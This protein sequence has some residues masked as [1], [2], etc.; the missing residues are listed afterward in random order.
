MFVEATYYLFNVPGQ[1]E[2][3]KITFYKV[4]PAMNGLVGYAWIELSAEMKKALNVTSVIY[5]QAASNDDLESMTKSIM[6]I[7]PYSKPDA[8]DPKHLICSVLNKEQYS[9]L[10]T[11]FLTTKMMG[12]AKPTADGN[13]EFTLTDNDGNSYGKLTVLGPNNKPA[14]VINVLLLDEDLQKSLTSKLGGAFSKITFCLAKSEEQIKSD[15]ELKALIAGNWVILKDKK[16]T[17]Y[18]TFEDNGNYNVDVPNANEDELLRQE[19][20]TYEIKGGIL[21]RTNKNGEVS[22][23]AIIKN[24]EKEKTLNLEYVDE[25]GTPTGVVET[26][27]NLYETL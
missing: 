11:P 3:D 18:I 27:T 7:I 6:A 1:S 25:K 15:D 4:L 24:I 13:T 5:M 9:E 8:Q 2:K 12:T 20:G 10:I 26:Y 17:T 16:I 21:I 23:L 19:E 14:D 22:S